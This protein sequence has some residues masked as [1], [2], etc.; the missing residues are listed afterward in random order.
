LEQSGRHNKRVGAILLG[1]GG[2]IALIGTGLLIAAAWD[3]SDCVHHNDGFHHHIDCD[4]SALSIA[5][6]TTTLLGIGVLAPG[7][8]IYVNGGSQVARAR[9]LRSYYW[10]SASL[11]PTLGRGAVGLE[12]QLSH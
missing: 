9:R 1:T 2:G 4:H 12:L 8:G 7:V 10:G 6:A 11:R 5:G 3:D